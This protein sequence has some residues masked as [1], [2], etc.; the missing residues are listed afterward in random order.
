M[1]TRNIILS[2]SFLIVGLILGAVI[3]YLL[4]PETSSIISNT[5]PDTQNLDSSALQSAKL[6]QFSSYDSLKNFLKTKTSSNQ[7]YGNALSKSSVMS[8]AVMSF[9]S[10]SGAGAAVP[11]SPSASS[12]SSTNIQVEGVDEPDITKNDGKYIYTISGNNLVIAEVY[13]AEDMKILSKIKIEGVRDLFINK[14]K[15]I[16]FSQIYSYIPYS[17]VRC[18][19]LEYCGGTSTSSNFVNIYDVSD[20]SNPELVQNISIEGNYNSARMIGDYVYLVS[21]KDVYNDEPIFPLCKV[22]GRE[23]DFGLSDLYY[24]PYHDESYVFTSVSSINTQKEEFNNKIFLTGYTSTIYVSQNNIYITSTDYMDYENYREEIVKKAILPIVNDEIKSKINDVLLSDISG[25]EKFNEAGKIVEDYYNSLSEQE[26]SSFNETLTGQVKKARI[27]LEKQRYKTVI[28][29][30][31]VDKDKVDFIGKGEVLGTVLNQFSMDEYNGN[32][33]IATTSGNSWWWFGERINSSNNLYV[34]DKDLKQIGAIED[35]AS[36]ET[37]YSARFVG[38]RAYMVTYR[39]VDPLFVIDL[40]DAQP[41]VL[42]YLKITGVSN[43]LHPYDENHIIGIGQDSTEDGRL[44]GMKISLFDVSDVSNPVEKA[45][46]LIGDRGTSSEALYDHKAVLFDK[47]KNLL[48]VPISLYE[49]D[50]SKQV[51]EWSYTELTWQGAYVLNIDLTG[52]TL[53]GKISHYSEYSPKY[54]AASSDPVGYIRDIGGNKWTKVKADSWKSVNNKYY[55]EWGVSDDDI[56]LMKG[57]INYKSY[58]YDYEYAIKRSLY[59][60]DV[61]YTISP[62]KIKANNLETIQEIKSLDL[63]FE[64]NSYNSYY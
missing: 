29:K 64:G 51:Y 38:D 30:V 42:G 47:D 27:E 53:R 12:Y 3:L 57:G 48:V 20:K 62:S 14:D 43:Y 54:G 49:A 31:L 7:G 21:T 36:G 44:L 56:D 8:E 45:K 23:I 10:S 34:L 39:R 50:K 26:K 15:L 11:Q 32:L 24:A 9:D 59:M 6:S 52:I 22:N 28:Y 18:L 16:V 41:E 60:D 5:N 13:P 55:D 2:V 63:G 17:N 61:L 35:L 4:T 19:G 25:Y 40:S 37:I 1:N 33:R 46:I 58:M